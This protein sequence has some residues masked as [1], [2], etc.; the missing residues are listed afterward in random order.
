MVTLSH[1]HTISSPL[2][3]TRVVGLFTARHA[4]FAGSSLTSL[5]GD[6]SS[7]RDE[8]VVVESSNLASTVGYFDGPFA[9]KPDLEAVKYLKDTS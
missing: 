9:S 7:E 4:M 5:S 8:D 2:N 3:A 6:G 1:C